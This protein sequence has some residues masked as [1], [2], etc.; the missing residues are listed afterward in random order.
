MEAPTPDLDE[1]PNVSAEEQAQ[2]D[3]FINNALVLIYSDQTFP[4]IRQMLTEASKPDPDG[5]EGPKPGPTDVLADVTVLVVRRVEESGREA[6]QTLSQDV[7][8]HGGS[9]ILADLA[10]LCEKAQIHTFSDEEIE[11]AWFKALDRYMAVAS[12]AGELNPDAFQSDFQEILRADEAGQLGA[13]VPGVEERFP[14]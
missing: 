8:F 12:S 6:G 5:V 14:Q 4:Q 10:D 9:E 11:A 7:V 2:Y 1:Q 13:L 3:Q